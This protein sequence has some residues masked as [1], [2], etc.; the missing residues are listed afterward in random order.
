MIV[1]RPPSGSHDE[2]FRML[3]DF[4]DQGHLCDNV[5]Y[6]CGDFNID[7]LHRNDVKAKSLV[8]FLRT[9]GL[10]QHISS[11]TCITGFSKSCIDFIISNR[12]E[13]LIVKSC[14]LMGVLSD[15]FPVFLCV[16]K[17]RSVAKFSKIKGRTYRKYDK[18]LPYKP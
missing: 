10:K 7:F 4:I 15:H 2:F 16:K 17:Q 12:P 5:L 11:H 13:N 18:K 8:T 3:S 9:F 6:I 14:V 1:Y